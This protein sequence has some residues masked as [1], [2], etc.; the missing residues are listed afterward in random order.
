MDVESSSG[1]VM[2]PSEI[3]TKKLFM[4]LLS[5]RP[6]AYQERLNS[7]IKQGKKLPR[8]WQPSIPDLDSHLDEIGII[9]DDD[10]QNELSGY[11]EE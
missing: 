1:C 9:E 6:I 8:N 3:K 7:I 4:Y 10:E 5:K 11:E 2:I